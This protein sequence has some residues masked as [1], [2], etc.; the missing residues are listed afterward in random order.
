VVPH[1]VH[2]IG[3]RPAKILAVVYMPC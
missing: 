2:A 3:D 1:D